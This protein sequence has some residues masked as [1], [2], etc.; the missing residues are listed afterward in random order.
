[1]SNKIESEQERKIRISKA[2]SKTKDLFVPFEL[3]LALY[4]LGFNEPC[5]KYQWIDKKHSE[6]MSHS[7]KQSIFCFQKEY[8]EN[9][10]IYTISIPLYDQAFNW[11]R[12]NYNLLSHIEKGNN[13]ENYYPVIDNASYRYKP[14]SWFTSYEEAQLDCLKKLIKIVNE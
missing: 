3:A 1:M 10:Q 12:K 9:K 5:L 13:P 8:Q 11:F 7:I 2:L 14:E 6:W 4:N